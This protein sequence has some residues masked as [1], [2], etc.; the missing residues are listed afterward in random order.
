[1]SIPAA[2]DT[3]LAAA[4]AICPLEPSDLAFRTDYEPPDAFRLSIVDQLLVNPR[5]TAAVAE[6]LGSELRA[7]HHGGGM[8]GK[9]AAAVDLELGEVV[10]W[11]G[12]LGA[13]EGAIEG[14]FNAVALRIVQLEKQLATGME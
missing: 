8:V 14:A 12:G 2:L 3:V 13:L 9:A 10:A 1:M 7:A 5:A 6:S 11:S 4:L